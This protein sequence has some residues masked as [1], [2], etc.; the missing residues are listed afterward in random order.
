MLVTVS[1]YTRSQ[2]ANRFQHTSDT[3]QNNWYDLTPHSK[4]LTSETDY[5]TVQQIV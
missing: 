2:E 1:M 4:N 5:T 3:M